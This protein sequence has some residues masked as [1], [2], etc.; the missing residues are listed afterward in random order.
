MSHLVGFDYE[1]IVT[2]V[3]SGLGEDVIALGKSKGAKGATLFHGKGSGIHDTARFFALE[4][5]PEKDMVLILVPK[6]LTNSVLQ[7]IAV[8]M[9]MDKPGNGISF[10]IDVSKIVGITQLAQDSRSIELSELLKEENKD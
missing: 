9:E 3:E 10:V 1:L 4:I 2:I 7:A 8:G 5:E 6:S